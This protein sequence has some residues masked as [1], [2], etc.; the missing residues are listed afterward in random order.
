[1]KDNTAKTMRV[2]D[3]EYA[4]KGAFQTAILANPN[5]AK[6]IIEEHGI[7]IS[8][9]LS[10]GINNYTMHFISL[11]VEALIMEK[12]RKQEYD[13]KNDKAD[14][15]LD[16]FD[17]NYK[18]IDNNQ[19]HTALSQAALFCDG[20]LAEAAFTVL[21][22][23]L[24]KGADCNQTF[25]IP[26]HHNEKHEIPL[27]FH[28][29]EW[30]AY[31]NN[32]V[33]N[34]ELSLQVLKCLLSKEEL[35][36][37]VTANIDGKIYN[38]ENYI[39]AFIAKEKQQALLDIINAKTYIKSD[40]DL[41]KDPSEDDLPVETHIKSGSDL[42]ESSDDLPNPQT[43]KPAFIFMPHISIAAFIPSVALPIL[44]I[45]LNIKANINNVMGFPAGNVIVSFTSG[46]LSALSVFA[47]SLI[48]D[49]ATKNDITSQEWK[50]AGINSLWAF[51]FHTAIVGIQEIGHHYLPAETP[52]K[53]AT[54]VVSAILMAIVDFV[55]ASEVEKNLVK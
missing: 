38:L 35:D 5:E 29:V 37:T 40:F 16:L 13:L 15:L 41:K 9:D 52:W 7:N 11:I 31:N 32:F 14:S 10:A 43:K 46:L 25:A 18:Y 42:K 45:E 50:R 53:I 33:T 20:I 27:I 21:L 8:F 49:K 22:K 6:K 2:E 47:T 51:T 30:F 17:V 54:Y 28:A 34:K 12:R 4:H 24:I 44:F 23:L 39:Q 26:A 48:Y 36:L 3:L 19:N 55:V 1:M